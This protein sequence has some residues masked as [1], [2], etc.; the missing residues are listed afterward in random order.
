LHDRGVIICYSQEGERSG[1]QAARLAH[2]ILKGI[3]ASSLPIEQANFYLGINLKA[4]EAIG[5][6]IPGDVLAGAD[7]IVR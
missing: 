6:N 5:L 1:M 3:P 2:E 7:F 4:A